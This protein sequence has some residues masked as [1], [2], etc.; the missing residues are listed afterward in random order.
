MIISFEPPQATRAVAH[1]APHCYGLMQSHD[2][3]II[4]CSVL[5]YDNMNYICSYIY[6]CKTR[7]HT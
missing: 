1:E 4:L 7:S 6:L 2:P 3:D 5:K